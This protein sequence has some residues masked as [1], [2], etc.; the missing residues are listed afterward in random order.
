MRGIRKNNGISKNRM[1]KGS[2]LNVDTCL[3]CRKVN[4]EE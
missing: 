3:R 4:D 2:V 1:M